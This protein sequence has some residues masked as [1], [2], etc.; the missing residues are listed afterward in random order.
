MKREDI[1]E[2]LISTTEIHGGHIGANLATIELTAGLFDVFDIEKDWV[3]F[4]TGHQGYTYKILTG[5]SGEFV[6]LNK[7]GGMSRFISRSESLYDRVDA[8]HAGTAISIATGLSK[9]DQEN[10]TIAIIGDGT[11]VE[12]MTWEGLNYAALSTKLL[13]VL[14]DNEIAI[15]KNVGGVNSM[16][17]SQ[18][19]KT[20]SK[21]FFEA[22]GFR[23]LYCE[24]GHNFERI[25]ETYRMAKEVTTPV[26]VHIKTIKGY[27]LDIA[28]NHPYK[29]HFSQ[30]FD[31]KNLSTASAV[32]IGLSFAKV[33]SDSII[34][35]YKTN[36]F[37]GRYFL[38]A[39]TPYASSLEKFNEIFG[40]NYIDVGM[41]EQQLLGMA[42]GISLKG[43]LPNVFVQATFLQRSI[44]QIIHDLAFMKLRSNIFVVRSGFAGQDSPTHHAIF[45]L[46]I[47]TSI[48]NV[49][50]RYPSNL[51]SARELA[52]DLQLKVENFVDVVLLPYFPVDGSVENILLEDY[53]K[54]HY[55]LHQKT[56]SK[57]LL[58]SLSSSN[59][60]ILDYLN[61][62]RGHVFCDHLILEELTTDWGNLTNYLSQYTQ[63]LVL[64]E[65][66]IRSG[67][68]AQLSL[69]LHSSIVESVGVKDFV[70]AGT[71]MYSLKAAGMGLIDFVEKC[72][73]FFK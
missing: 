68:G 30:P 57:N 72:K 61:A 45:D 8:S 55:G 9:V 32:P 49:R 22:L 70:E 13:I 54:T 41:A 21:S 27:G 39:G 14:N 4:D 58:I 29:M 16:F 23:Y 10:W 64:E 2:F 63:I 20:R 48:P 53:Q 18:E 31:R 60:Y 17:T 25:V 12:G 15:D 5:R 69:I 56:A 38:T 36:S 51:A 62:C 46:S 37:A 66:V 44:D 42:A 33:V 47:L 67:L 59:N 35:F 19:W 73:H 1:R 50:V 3:V 52:Q 65:N 34:D 6:T 11:L 43:G 26:V 40:S 7:D 28:A 24:E 71:Q